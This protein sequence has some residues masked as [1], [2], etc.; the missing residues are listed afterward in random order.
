MNAAM[1]RFVALDLRI[2]DVLETTKTS[3]HHLYVVL[4]RDDDNKMVTLLCLHTRV[5]W[6]FGYDVMTTARWRMFLED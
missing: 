5:V 1:T 4:S 3:K 2:G 6:D